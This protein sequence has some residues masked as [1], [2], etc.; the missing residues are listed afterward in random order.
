MVTFEEARNDGVV[1]CYDCDRCCRRYDHHCPVLGNCIGK[2]N[3][4]SFYGVVA[5]FILG[6]MSAY[7]AMYLVLAN[8]VATGSN[9]ADAI[10]PTNIG[11]GALVNTIGQMID[12]ANKNSASVG[13]LPKS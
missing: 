1:H 12:N 7:F 13:S 9:N 10:R 4:C 8:D 2:R 6:V 3:T 5:F 11:M